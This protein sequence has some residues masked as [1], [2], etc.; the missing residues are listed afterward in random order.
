MLGVTGARG[1]TTPLMQS[2]TALGEVLLVLGAASSVVQVLVPI[3]ASMAPPAMRGRVVG[4]VMSGLLVGILLSRP[5]ASAL[6]DRFGW[7]AFFGVIAAAM[8]RLTVFLATRLHQ[9]EPR[10][11]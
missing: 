4:D 1:A 11:R 5:L 7:R 8:A 9:R 2:A 3:A 6:A 10:S